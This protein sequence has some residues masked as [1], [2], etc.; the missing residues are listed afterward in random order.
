VTNVFTHSLDGAVHSMTAEDP[1]AVYRL[2]LRIRRWIKTGEEEE[3]VEMDEVEEQKV[4]LELQT[5]R[6]MWRISGGIQ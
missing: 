4:E 1:W 2:T 5:V 3:K 6:K